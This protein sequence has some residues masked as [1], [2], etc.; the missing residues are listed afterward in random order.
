[1]RLFLWCY[2]RYS[3]K[4]FQ[5]NYKAIIIL[6]SKTE[7]LSPLVRRNACTT[8]AMFGNLSALKRSDFAVPQICRVLRMVHYLEVQKQAWSPTE[9]DADCWPESS[10]RFPDFHDRPSLPYHCCCKRI[11][12]LNLQYCTPVTVPKH[13]KAITKQLFIKIF[14]MIWIVCD[15]TFMSSKRYFLPRLNSV[16][17]LVS[18]NLR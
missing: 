3:S 8:I 14:Q 7:I 4:T 9:I 2:S 1:M 16:W 18:N 5:S 10:P 13:F 15:L 11:V 12:T 17:S 6:L